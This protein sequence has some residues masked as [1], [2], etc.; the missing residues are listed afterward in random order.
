MC[1]LPDF[2]W[3]HLG[4][5]ISIL[6]WLSHDL[7]LFFRHLPCF[8]SN[9]TA[10]KSRVNGTF[11]LVQQI[12]LQ[13]DLRVERV[14]SRARLLELESWLYQSPA[15]RPWESDFTFLG[16]GFLRLTWGS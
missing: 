7:I 5:R 16:L 11:W 2:V 1:S 15:V 13:K 4:S 6:L 8:F 10:I 3:F 9:S 12:L 14:D